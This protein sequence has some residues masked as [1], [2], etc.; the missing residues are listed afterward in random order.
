[1]DTIHLS[2]LAWCN[3]YLRGWVKL[4]LTVM[5]F[6]MAQA[7]KCKQPK[8]CHLFGYS[9]GPVEPCPHS[10]DSSSLTASSAVNACTWWSPGCCCCP[11]GLFI[12][13]Y[14]VWH[15]LSFS[16]FNL[17]YV[18]CPFYIFSSVF[19]LSLFCL[20]QS[21]KDNRFWFMRTCV[22]VL[23]LVHSK[24]WVFWSHIPHAFSVC[25]LFS[26]GFGFEFPFMCVLSSIINLPIHLELYQQLSMSV[27]IW[28]LYSCWGSEK[29]TEDVIIVCN[30]HTCCCW[31]AL[32]M[33]ETGAVVHTA[34]FF[35][36][37]AGFSLPLP[38]LVLWSLVV[39]SGISLSL[40]SVCLAISIW[41]K[42]RTVSTK[43]VGDIYWVSFCAIC[44]IWEI[45][46]HFWEL[47]DIGQRHLPRGDLLAFKRRYF[48]FP[49]SFLSSI[50]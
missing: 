50:H 40:V 30:C 33:R 32:H 1:M 22:Y 38:H 7:S 16:T 9:Q 36:L 42:V 46:R 8:W 4:S 31:W 23:E 14:G 6:L 49:F 2:L 43:R 37:V 21:W 47:H 25:S 35:F 29:I 41:G 17:A 13:I 28:H 24:W 39:S 19:L 34:F 11:A 48:C 5:S 20:V 12:N 45:I 18:F 27:D 15:L 10:E 3:Q 44:S 26:S